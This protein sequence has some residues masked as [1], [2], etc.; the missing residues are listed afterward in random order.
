MHI[1][2]WKVCGGQGCW[3]KLNTELHC[4]CAGSAQWLSW[5]KVLLESCHCCCRLWSQYVKYCDWSLSTSE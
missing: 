4:R 5:W 2:I 1:S 3:G